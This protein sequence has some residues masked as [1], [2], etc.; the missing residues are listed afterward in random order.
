[1]SR[2]GS[3]RRRG[4]ELGVAGTRS[5]PARDH[6]GARGRGPAT[7]APRG[8][9]PRAATGCRPRAAARAPRQPACRTSCR[10]RTS[11]QRRSGSSARLATARCTV[12]RPRRSPTR[13]VARLVVEGDPLPARARKPRVNRPRARYALEADVGVR[14]VSHRTFGRQHREFRRSLANSP[15]CPKLAGMGND[16]GE[17]KAV[18]PA[19]LRD[20]DQ[21]VVVTFRYPVRFTHGLLDP[22]NTTLRDV[23]QAEDRA[24]LLVVD[25][26]GRRRR[27]SRDDRRRR[28]R[29]APR[30]PT[31]SSSP[32]RRWSSPAARRSRTTPGRS[33]RSAPRS[34]STASTATRT[35]SR[36]AAARC[37]TRSATRRRP[38]IAACG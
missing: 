2:Q 12:R 35:S 1:M 38:P 23:V 27:A 31:R 16:A 18:G 36:S 19:R 21:E 26:R 24:R 34:T 3:G 14:A 25:R 4:S 13:S 29:T 28:R 37:S 5:R 8:E 7:S 6:R 17:D 32:R 9:A 33:T 30:T 10:P 15:W 20:I 22:G 11:F